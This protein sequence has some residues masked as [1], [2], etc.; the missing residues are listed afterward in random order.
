[1]FIKK[2]ESILTTPFLLDV[3]VVTAE[4]AVTTWMTSL[5]QANNTSK[6]CLAADLANLEVSMAFASPQLLPHVADLLNCP[7]MDDMPNDMWAFGVALH[8]WLTCACGNYQWAFGPPRCGSL[9]RAA[10]GRCCFQA[11]VMGTLL[12][13]VACAPPTQHDSSQESGYVGVVLDFGWR[14]FVLLG[15]MVL[16]MCLPEAQP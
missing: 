5:I 14:L 15:N 11:R 16:R 3:V 7:V 9:P 4:L 6:L 8:K 13:C 10:A 1:M 2:V 12:P